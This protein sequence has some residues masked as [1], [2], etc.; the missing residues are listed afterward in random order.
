MHSGAAERVHAQVDGRPANHVHVDHVA[1]I[2]DVGTEIVVAMRGG[3]VKSLRVRNLLQVAKLAF[4]KL[5]RPGFDP[6]RDVS[7]RRV[8]RWEG[9]T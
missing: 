3:G 6:A 7:L 2:H 5:V 9:C 1:E 4:E 8:R